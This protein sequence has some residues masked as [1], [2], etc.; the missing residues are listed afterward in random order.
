MSFFKIGLLG[1]FLFV[2]INNGLTINVGIYEPSMEIIEPVYDNRSIAMGKTSTTTARGSSTIFSNPAILGSFSDPQIQI[3]GKI[4]Y[5]TIGNESSN[6][7]G[8]SAYESKYPAHLSRSFF[9]LTLPYEY[10]DKLK[11]VFGIGYQRNEG[12]KQDTEYNINPENLNPGTIILTDIDI[13]MNKINRFQQTNITKGQLDTLTP[14]IAINFQNKYFIG[15]TFNQVV[16]KIFT[17]SDTK[18]GSDKTFDECETEQSAL[19][20]RV[21]AFTKLTP[22][23]VVSLMYRTA[24]EWKLGDSITIRDKYGNPKTKRDQLHIERPIPAILGIGTEYWVSPEFAVA[25]EVQS[26]PLSKFKYTVHGGELTVDD[27]F[28]VS[29]GA[30]Y[31]GLGFP[32]RV[33]AFRDVIPEV[34]YNDTVPNSLIGVTAGI[35]S[36]NDENFSWNASVLLAKWETRRPKGNKY[37]ENLFRMGISGTYRFKK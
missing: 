1:I 25:I 5:G 14:G 23:L 31:L 36:N 18:F 17:T 12:V 15:A 22:Q 27:G 26:R 8:L 35:G 7:L 9:A 3:G 19:F 29:V 37:S 33:G 30:E 16:G 4:F 28:K 34:N 32:F 20:L 6:Y 2:L 21:G 10:N 11:L 13:N 24:F